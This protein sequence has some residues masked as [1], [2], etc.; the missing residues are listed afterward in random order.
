MNFPIV[1]TRDDLRAVMAELIPPPVIL[2]PEVMELERLKRTEALT[3]QEVEKLYGLN[4]NTLRYKRVQ[5]EGPEYLK[6]GGRVLYTH[7][8]IKKYLESCRQ[9]IYGQ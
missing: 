5:G 7:A 3:S 6:D 2:S 9:R 8:A 4:A 1:T